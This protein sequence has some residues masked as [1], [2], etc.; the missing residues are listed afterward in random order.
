MYKYWTVCVD[1]V[2]STVEQKDPRAMFHSPNAHPSQ[3]LAAESETV[4]FPEEH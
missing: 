1:V 3:A 4:S 2:H